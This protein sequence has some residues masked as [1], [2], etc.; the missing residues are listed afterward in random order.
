MKQSLQPQPA[1]LDSKLKQ[2]KRATLG[3]TAPTITPHQ[4]WRKVWFGQDLDQTT[5][6]FGYVIESENVVFPTT[7]HPKRTLNENRQST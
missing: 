5:R 7:N 1:L 3:K 2:T 6:G 4:L